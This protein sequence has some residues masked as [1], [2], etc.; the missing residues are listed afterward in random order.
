MTASD[1]QKRRPAQG[2]RI[3]QD[4]ICTPRPRA[5][6]LSGS[7]VLYRCPPLDLRLIT[8]AEIDRFCESVAITPAC[9]LWTGR[10]NRSTYGT[11]TIGGRLVLAH[12][13]SWAL[14]RGPVPLGVGVLHHCDIPTCVNPEHLF[15]GTPKANAVDSSNKHRCARQGQRTQQK[16]ECR[17]CHKMTTRPVYCSVRCNALSHI[18]PHGRFIRTSLSVSHD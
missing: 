6:A 11:V 12:R 1:G 2:S 18:G 8:D 9:W 7:S 16:R 3:S 15:L 10:L 4:S 14:F 17:R 5:A 13:A